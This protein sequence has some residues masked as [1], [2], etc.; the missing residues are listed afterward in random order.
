MK[1]V[2]R[3]GN[4]YIE[5]GIQTCLR[6]AGLHS[7]VRLPSAAEYLTAVVVMKPCIH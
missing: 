5:P 4:I 1:K 2:S 7:E 3:K 6:E